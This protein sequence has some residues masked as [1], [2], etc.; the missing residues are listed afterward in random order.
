MPLFAP[1]NS[2]LHLF[3]CRKVL[4]VACQDHTWLVGP[5]DLN[6]SS[7]NY[8]GALHKRVVQTSTIIRVKGI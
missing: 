3:D 7:L 5:Y 8:L 1:S 2:Q 4:E 6:I